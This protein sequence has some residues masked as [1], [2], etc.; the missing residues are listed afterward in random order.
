MDYRS[1]TGVSAP[2]RDL[3]V[4]YG[5][6]VGYRLGTRARV[7]VDAE[8]SHRSSEREESREF[9]NHRIVALLNWGALNR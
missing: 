6:G 1:F 3:L 8:F 2:G 9:R 7:A 5:G 4:L